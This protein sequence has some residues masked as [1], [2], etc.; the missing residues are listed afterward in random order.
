MLRGP[1]GVPVQH[2]HIRTRGMWSSR[3][4]LVDTGAGAAP[5]TQRSVLVRTGTITP[6]QNDVLVIDG[7]S[8]AVRS[9]PLPEEDGGIT[10]YLVA[11]V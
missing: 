4:Q 1:L 10:R 9:P 7:A 6:D 5:D 2:G 3:G 8:F 11:P